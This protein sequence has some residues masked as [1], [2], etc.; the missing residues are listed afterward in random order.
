MAVK[1]ADESN[2]FGALAYLLS[3]ITGIIFLLV[4]PKDQYVKYHSV[5]SILLSVAAII[6][7]IVWG[8]IAG[9]LTVATLG[10]GLAVVLPVSGLIYLVFLIAWLYSMWEA[11]NGRKHKLPLIGEYAKKYA[12]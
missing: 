2:L 10:V 11:F 7:Q 1:V 6:V 9:I 4:K 8:V 12:K 3:F 5:Q